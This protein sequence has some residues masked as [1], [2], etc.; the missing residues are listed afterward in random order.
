MCRYSLGQYI[1]LA[2]LFLYQYAHQLLRTQHQNAE[3]QVAVDFLRALHH[4]MASAEL[5]FKPR[6]GALDGAA[7]FV[8]FSVR[9]LESHKGTSV[10]TL[11][12]PWI[13]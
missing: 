5:V 3:N 4:R 8:A 10:R 2:Q 12:L 6:V 7:D 9:E 1:D 11:V 13:W